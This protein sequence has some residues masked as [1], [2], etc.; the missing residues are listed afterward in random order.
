MVALR[1]KG[2][3]RTLPL[4]TLAVLLS[5][6]LGC[7]L[8]EPPPDSKP[9]V[10]GQEAVRDAVALAMDNK[11]RCLEVGRGGAERLEEESLEYQ[12][13]PGAPSPE[14]SFRHYI[15]VEA[16][17]ELAAASETTKTIAGLLPLV[18]KEA[19]PELAQ[20][21]EELAS[22]Q[23]VVCLRAEEKAFTAASYE[24]QIS[25]A[26]YGYES[27]LV[28]VELRFTVTPGDRALVAARY[29]SA[30]EEAA[31]RARRTME[32]AESW[33]KRDEPV[34]A[35]ALPQKSPEEL[36][37][38]RREWEEHQRIVAEKE[39]AHQAA[40]EQWRRERAQREETV[41]AQKVRGVD[42]P[43][44]A[45]AM[46]TWHATYMPKAAP[47]RSALAR[48]LPRAAKTDLDTQEICQGLLDSTTAL[49]DDK[50]ALDAPDR[51]VGRTLEQAYKEFQGAARACLAA[52]ALEA[53]FRL[54]DGEAALGRAASLLKAYSLRP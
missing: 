25:Q 27:A 17:P 36:A 12:R 3:S 11:D 23:R 49:L 40:L 34:P 1:W 18:K 51:K 16:A 2:P 10:K 22:A 32:R 54:R 13:N 30:I 33:K 6:G 38:E 29:R 50:T 37:R 48:Y 20:A 5:G 9:L 8:T 4:W 45:E 21:V 7:G 35:A 31:D 19:S 14:K 39:A 15:E 41:P 43:V 26:V 47:V 42:E 28:A 24:D 53:H 44:S 46:K 52:N